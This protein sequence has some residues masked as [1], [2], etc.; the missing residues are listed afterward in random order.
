VSWSASAGATIT[1]GG[2]ATAMTPG[3]VTIKATQGNI[4]GTATM[5]VTTACMYTLS[6]VMEGP[7]GDT[8][9]G[10]IV[11]SDGRIN[12][13]SI[14]SATYNAGSSVTLS[15]FGQSGSTLFAGWSGGG[16]SGN[17]KCGLQINAD[18]SV[19]ARWTQTGSSLAY[20]TVTPSNVS[21]YGGDAVRYTATGWW[22]DGSTRDITGNV[23]WSASPAGVTISSSGLAY[24][25]VFGFPN[26]ITATLGNIISTATV[27][28]LNGAPPCYPLPVCP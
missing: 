1:S 11:S 7:G 26:T 2:L 27:T 8:G 25:F 23:S 19:T 18:T 13:P 16:C 17:G 9:T 14:C 24:N 5:T 21:V 22:D 15:P 4:F 3:S 6:V 12:C 10:S 20:I 28:V